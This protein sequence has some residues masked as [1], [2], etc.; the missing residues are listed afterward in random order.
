MLR[1]MFEFDKDNKLD[2]WLVFLFL[3]VVAGAFGLHFWGLTRFS[4]WE[5][6]LYSIG[7]VSATGGW[8]AGIEW[9]KDP[10]LLTMQDGFWT[11]KLTDP[12]PF[13]YDAVLWIWVKIFGVS[14]F[15]VRSLSALIGTAL[16]LTAAQLSR[17]LGRS[18][19]IL[20]AFVLTGSF[21]V[22][23]ESQDCRSYI[24][25]ALLSSFVCIDFVKILS[26]RRP[27]DQQL[28]EKVA[29]PSWR[30]LMEVAALCLTHYYGILLAFAVF[31][32]STVHL[33]R[34]GAA[35]TKI[36]IRWSVAM[37]PVF[38]YMVVGV[39][40][41]LSKTN[42]PPGIKFTYAQAAVFL[43]EQLGAMIAPHYGTAA[44]CLLGI[45]GLFSAVKMKVGAGRVGAVTGRPAFKDYVALNFFMVLCIFFLLM[46][47]TM[48][49]AEYF[50]PRYFIFIVPVMALF[51]AVS[52]SIGKWRRCIAW[53]MILLSVA[54]GILTWRAIDHPQNW[55]DWRGSA[56][57]I[58][59]NYEKGDV[60][61]EPWPPIHM[62]YAHY[63]SQ[64]I[65]GPGS[66]YL[67]GLASVAELDKFL[68]K[69]KSPPPKIF[70][71]YHGENDD[72]I[73]AMEK[74]V[75]D[76]YSCRKSIQ[77]NFLRLHVVVMDCP[78]G[79]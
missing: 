20:Y 75:I 57:F 43:L 54:S 74:F 5:D 58:A 52:G 38:A 1:N 12:H 51:L 68:G 19:S 29:G 40:G 70:I 17:S 60:V 76:R 66:D 34:N 48:R 59:S 4:L 44:V 27:D 53:V 18:V 72:V 11:W 62:Y 67:V 7:L 77:Q 21:I 32:L 2:S 8:G 56:R 3:L 25:A 16:V 26:T 13:L 55:G 30:M 37:L 47:V 23:L 63:L 10:N 15:A 69:L 46:A 61:I 78:Q 49:R 22:L 24:L 45:L 42:A 71:Y 73:L 39:H 9:A 31:L 33:Q 14:D 35:L 6:E 36:I 79:G 65:P 50:N 64:F 41:I 28:A